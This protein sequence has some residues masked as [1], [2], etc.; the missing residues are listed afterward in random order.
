MRKRLLGETFHNWYRNIIRHPKWRW[1]VL[2][3]TLL[4][5][6]SPIDLSPDVFPVIGW[7]DDGLIATL[8]VTELSQILLEN[9]RRFSYETQ[10][11]ETD[12]V[13]GTVIDVPAVTVS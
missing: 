8:A 5:L 2:L 6:V 12:E 7:I 11:V 9:R 10:T 13:T 3:G 1:W 4:Y